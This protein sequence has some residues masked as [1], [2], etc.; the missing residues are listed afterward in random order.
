MYN[1]LFVCLGNI[2]R[3]PTAEG[4]MRDLVKEEGL[5][6]KIYID[7]A[8]ISGW[9]EGEAPDT[10]AVACARSFG[11]DISD[12]RS[13][14]V[15]SEDFAKFDLILGMDN[16]NMLK[17]NEISRNTISTAK[18]GRLLDYAPSYGKDVPDPYYN[19]SFDY[20]YEIISVACENLLASLTQQ[21]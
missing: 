16:Q 13:R 1:I 10:R 8:G 19:N 20:V 7:S 18:I 17:L 4:L 21:K 12:L 5:S 9:H 2:C 6:D 14:Q 11:T 3:S 15:D